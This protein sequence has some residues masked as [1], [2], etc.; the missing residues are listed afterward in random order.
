MRWQGCHNRLKGNWVSN[1]A[2]KP[3]NLSESL[4]LKRVVSAEN[5]S[6]TIEFEAGLH[7]CHSGGVVQGGFVTGWI[8]SAMAHAIIGRQADG[9]ENDV[10]PVSLEL[11]ISFFAPARPGL[12]IAKAWVERAGRSTSFMEGQLSDA[13]GQILAKG[14]STVRLMSKSRIVAASA[15]ALG[16]T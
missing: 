5:G 8:D 14:S 16:S 12:V 11:K 6:A 13:S 9:G 2:D 15:A 1:G 7:M 4:G 10:T 3:G